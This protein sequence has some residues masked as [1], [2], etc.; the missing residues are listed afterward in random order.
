M[1][2]KNRIISRNVFLTVLKFLFAVTASC[3]QEVKNNITYIVSP[4]FPA[5]MSA[6]IK[7]C[8]L[9]VKM[10]S[11][12]ISQLRFDFVHFSMVAN[13]RCNFGSVQF[14]GIFQLI[15]RVNRIDGRVTVMAIYSH[16]SVGRVGNSGFAD[17]IM[18]NT[19]S[20]AAT[21]NIVV[22]RNDI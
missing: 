13:E 20:L 15:F 10:M 14:N 16:C 7:T 3:D 22:T 5:L 12:D 2:R 8:K 6:D 11:P 18:D 9:K 1:F 21:I 4:S 19:V 17:K